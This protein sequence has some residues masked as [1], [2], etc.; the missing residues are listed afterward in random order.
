MS[1]MGQI[2]HDHLKATGYTVAGGPVPVAASMAGGGGQMVA[3]YSAIVRMGAAAT[4]EVYT[5]HL[6][7]RPAPAHLRDKTKHLSLSDDRFLQEMTAYI[8][9]IDFMMHFNKH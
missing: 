9:Q 2:V 3:S 7:I 1:M 4:V 8:D 5:D 6:L